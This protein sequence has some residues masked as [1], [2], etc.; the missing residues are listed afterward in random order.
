VALKLGEL[1]A[2]L[3]TDNSGLDRGLEEGKEKVRQ[4][5]RDMERDAGTSGKNIGAAIG[6]GGAG[7]G[8]KFARDALGRLH[9]SN[10]R[11]VAEGSGL[12][13]AAST[14]IGAGFAGAGAALQSFTSDV[15]S[16]A[17]GA[18][19]IAPAL[20]GVLTLVLGLVPALYVLG[21]ALGSLPALFAGVGAVVG[22][23]G[24]GFMGLSDAFTKS[25]SSGGGAARSAQDLTAAHRAVTRAAQDVTRAERDV[26]DAQKAAA[27]ATLDVADA[28]QQEIQRRGE[29]S[30]NLAD[31]KLSV[32]DAVFGETDAEKALADAR[33]KGASTD[34]I[35]R[36]DLA[37]RKAQQT[38]IDSKAQVE[39]LQSAQDDATS[40]GIQGSDLVVAA[41]DREAAAVRRVQD[42]QDAAT[43]SVQRLADAEQALNAPAPAGGGGVAQQVTKLAPAAADAVARIKALG[44]AFDAL[45]LNVQQRLFAGVG[46]E[47]QAL[48]Y[49]W[50]PTLQSRL[51][52]TATSLNGLFRQL[53][54]SARQPA[55][56]TGIAGGID[57]VNDMID[58]VGRSIPHLIDAFGRL[59][60]SAGPFISGLGDVITG[61]IDEFDRWIAS[62]DKSGTLDAFFGKAADFLHD[63]AHVG[64]DVISIIGSILS[65]LF[66][67]PKNA[68]SSP[69][70][71]AQRSLDNLA[72]WFNNP[73]NQQKITDFFSVLQ[74]ALL[75]VGQHAGAI[76]DLA[77]VLG[78]LAAGIWLLVVATAA[79]NAVMA[80]SPVTWIVLGIM[81]IVAGIVLLARHTDDIKR[82]WGEAWGFIKNAASAVGT[83]FKDTL[84]GKWIKGAWN[85]I[86]G[87]GDRVV[88]WFRNLP[89]R[90]KSALV[91]V[92]D[93]LTAPFRAGFNAIARLWN[94]SVGKLHFTVPTWVPGFG[95]QG[96][97]LPTLPQLAQG[98]IVPA[99]P[100]GRLIV[101]GEGGESEVVAPLSKL[102]SIARANS[103]GGS[104][105]SHSE[106]REL[107]LRGEFRI[108]GSDL[109]LV[110][111]DKV[112]ERGGSVQAVLGSNQ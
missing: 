30:R 84:W 69:W 74:G 58:Q 42:A 14:G 36:L 32:E 22:V 100:G 25:A 85:S 38:V 45:R 53:T 87:A 82:L 83:W 29:L 103:R 60:G 99:T 54:T 81:L 9:D 70:E 46:G 35:A 64:K 21:G 67:S 93:F 52:G 89:G 8:E 39:Q 47:I 34:Q 88:G 66:T 27:Q 31:A 79:W 111:R 7:G 13:R 102:P 26:A 68:S 109:V 86:T 90:L 51:G 98:G 63:V 2:Y 18:W 76:G 78:P 62:A 1:V 92:A 28:V 95:G 3:K 50:L 19:S 61:V 107:L 48:A 33:A 43:D 37:Y 80:L 41:R 15:E 16:A 10:G 57:S 72:A 71:T 110:I 55:F 24:L 11:F 4:G 56:I 49:A 6:A 5:G 94:N 65:A 112:G 20:A 101:A 12:G 23:L 77:A 40:T 59:A 75:F 108:R 44:P 73:D 96:F 105:D 17:G 97:S 91:K 104:G 106:I